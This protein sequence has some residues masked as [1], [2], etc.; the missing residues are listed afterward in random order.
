MDAVDI[1]AGV[2]IA[3][4]CACA[5]A[6]AL[7]A[8]PVHAELLTREQMSNAA[9]RETQQA[10]AV[11]AHL[12]PRATEY[13][14]EQAAYAQQLAIQDDVNMGKYFMFY[15]FLFGWRSVEHPGAFWAVAAQRA[16]PDFNVRVHVFRI[17][18]VRRVHVC[19]II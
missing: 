6:Y 3:C 19:V 8:R 16:M 9:L 15:F 2:L 14:R 17:G 18:F 12:L 10:I 7:R 5:C 13:V 1:I 4:A 11:N